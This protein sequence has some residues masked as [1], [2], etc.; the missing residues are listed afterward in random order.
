M[1]NQSIQKSLV[2]ICVCVYMYPVQ[3]GAAWDV[4]L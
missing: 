4:M 3:G 1:Y 2:D